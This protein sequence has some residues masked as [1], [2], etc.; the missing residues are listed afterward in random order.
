MHD[1]RTAHMD[2]HDTEPARERSGPAGGN[3]SAY[4]RRKRRRKNLAMNVRR[5]QLPVKTK[6]QGNEVERPRH[7]LL[8]AIA[9]SGRM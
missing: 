8:N 3:T 1:A 9:A 4:L 7:G 5:R 2:L 6:A